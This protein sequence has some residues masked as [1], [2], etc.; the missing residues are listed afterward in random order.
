MEET[1]SVAMYVR[2]TLKTTEA[3]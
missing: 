3:F 1:A 2:S